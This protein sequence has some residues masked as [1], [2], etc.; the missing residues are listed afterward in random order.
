MDIRSPQIVMNSH[1]LPMGHASW[2]RIVA[3]I[4]LAVRIRIVASHSF[5]IKVTLLCV[6]CSFEEV[7]AH[8]S[9][10][11]HENTPQ[12]KEFPF[13]VTEITNSHHKRDDQHLRPGSVTSP[14][15]ILSVCA[16]VV[17]DVKRDGSSHVVGKNRQDGG[18][19]KS[20]ILFFERNHRLN[21]LA[22]LPQTIIRKLGFRFLDTLQLLHHQHRGACEGNEVVDPTS[23]L[24]Q[25]SERASTYI[26]GR[27]LV[28]V[29]IIHSLK[30]SRG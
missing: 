5:N 3:L 16:S 6:N 20:L 17:T 28:G 1:V 15:E 29:Q 30:Q 8:E 7:K 11:N 23:L 10:V 22:G 24:V 14:V 26:G 18:E 27:Y 4:G 9:Q 25:D 13:G 21:P 12:S 19:N 2:V